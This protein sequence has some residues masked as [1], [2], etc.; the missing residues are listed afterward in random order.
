MSDYS[1]DS[2]DIDTD[3]AASDAIAASALP[4]AAVDA[5]AQRWIG[6]MGEEGTVFSP[7]GVWPLLAIL[8]DVARAEVRS[9]LMAA[10]GLPGG[11]EGG[12]GQSGVSPTEMAIG[13]IRHLDETDGLS[14][15]AGIWLA[16]AI[17]R[18]EFVASL[19]PGTV[20]V[21]SGDKEA[22]QA[23][24][25]A[26]AN[27]RLGG[28]ISIQADLEEDTLGYLASAVSLRT[29]WLNRFRRVDVDGKPRLRRRIRE[30]G[31][32]RVSPDVTAVRVKG[33]MMEGGGTHD[34][35]LVLGPRGVAAREVLAR[36]VKAIRDVEPLSYEEALSAP[37]KPGPGVR[38]KVKEE[39]V[40]KDT[41]TPVLKITTPP[42]RVEATTQLDPGMCG[43]PADDYGFPGI[44]DTPLLFD[45]GR[46]QAV[47]EFTADG[48]SAAAYTEMR[49]CMARQ[50][51]PPKTVKVVYV[52]LE[53]D[54]AFGF[55]AV[56]RETG[57]LVF[58]GWVTEEEW[59][60]GRKEGASEEVTEQPRRSKRARKSR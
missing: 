15:A 51:P 18:P 58:V 8:A 33:K 59:E 30:E 52:S 11:D 9:D 39:V 5:F 43:L 48:F 56:E 44:T 35:Y 26:W 55:L 4:I 16:R 1:R 57:L 23:A 19:P 29:K 53:V 25:T 3:E 13:L 32:V 2:S 46:Q 10:L 38:I 41:T 27:A 7:V 28:I 31:T 36:G 60:G 22:D 37:A 12:S 34:V 42:F 40:R 54:R 50:P 6:R 14:A 20:E 49:G 17:A 21:L 24:I 45:G 47:A